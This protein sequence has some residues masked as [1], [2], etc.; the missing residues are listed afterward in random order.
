MPTSLVTKNMSIDSIEAINSDESKENLPLDSAD[1]AVLRMLLKNL[2]IS[3]SIYLLGKKHAYKNLDMEGNPEISEFATSY[4]LN[5][6]MTYDNFLLKGLGVALS[7][8]DLLNQ[9]PSFL[10]PYNGWYTP[11]PGPSREFLIKI[12]LKI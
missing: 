1:S 4:L 2:S 8:Y 11:Y 3:P 7:G 12:T 5:L 10:Q 6:T 9:K